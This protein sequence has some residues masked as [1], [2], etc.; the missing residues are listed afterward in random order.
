MMLMIE[1]RYIRRT[2]D[3]EILPSLLV[4]VHSRSV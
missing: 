3:D 1:A 2:L 4:S